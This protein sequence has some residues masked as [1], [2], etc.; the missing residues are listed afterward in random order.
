LFVAAAVAADQ[1]HPSAADGEIEDP[2]VRRVDHVQAHDLTYRRL[3]GVNRLAIGQHHVAEPAHRRVGRPRA[4][5][6]RDMAILDQQVIQR[7]GQLAVDGRPVRGVGGLD[8][9]RA[10][11]THLQAEILPHMRVVPVEPGV[12]EL[13]LASER[14]ADGDRL[15]R[16]VRDP[17][18]AVL[19]PQAVPM[20]GRLDIAVV[21]DVHRDFGALVDVQGRARDRSVVGQHPEEIAGDAVAYRADA[22]AEAK[23]LPPVGRA[24]LH[25]RLAA[26]ESAWPHRP[27][28]LTG[29]PH[30]TAD[31]SRHR[32]LK[33]HS[34]RTPSA[35]PNQRR[36]TP[37]WSARPAERGYPTGSE[38]GDRGSLPRRRNGN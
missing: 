32:G 5:E 19:Q 26:R 13:Q 15:L 4:Q 21:G 37:K 33:R 28:T 36:Q 29:H 6:R 12:G 30:Q 22:T 8:H 27:S 24:P 3:T 23:G 1:L 20:H 35:A 16:F 2:G 34:H 25:Q 10:V 31:R 38:L 18:V 9:D 14:S 17:V 7:D 11:Q